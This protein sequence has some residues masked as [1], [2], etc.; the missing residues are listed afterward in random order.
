[1]QARSLEER[2]RDELPLA[3]LFPASRDAKCAAG[4]RE[5]PAR[6]R[7]VSRNRMVH[8]PRLL[9]SRSFAAG[10]VTGNRLSCAIVQLCPQ[11]RKAIKLEIFLRND[12]VF[13]S[14]TTAILLGRM[15]IFRLTRTDL[16]HLTRT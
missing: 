13:V 11:R 7:R 15:Y 16:Q 12:L 2:L 1:M 9:R 3:G 14:I 10:V 8:G 5:R 6:G 4:G